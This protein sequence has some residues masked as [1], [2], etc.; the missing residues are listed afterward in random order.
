[1]DD[2]LGASMDNLGASM[3]NHQR[4]L[5]FYNNNFPAPIIVLAVHGWTIP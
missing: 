4:V 3:D 2:S 5:I 1:M